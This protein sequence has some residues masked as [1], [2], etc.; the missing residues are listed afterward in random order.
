ME[1]NPVFVKPWVLIPST[2]NKETKTLQFWARETAQWLRT[3]FFRGLEFDSQHS[4]QAAHNR[5]GVDGKVGVGREQEEIMEG[6]LQS[7]CKK[8]KKKVN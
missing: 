1:L 8:M 4:N 7:L 5:R 2:T 3:S 6:K